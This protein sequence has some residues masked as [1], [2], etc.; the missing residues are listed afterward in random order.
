M[1]EETKKDETTAQP[2]AEE[3]GRVIEERFK[4]IEGK[5]NGIVASHI[6]RGTTQ[7]VL[8]S[9]VAQRLEGLLPDVERRLLDSYTAS[10]TKAPEAASAE[11]KKIAEYEA[12]LKEMNERM[13][14]DSR[15]RAN[16][17]QKRL[18]LEEKSRLA[19]ELRLAGVPDSR[20]RAAVALVYT[21][22][23]RVGRNANGDV[24]YFVPKDGYTDEVSLSDGVKEW[25]K[26]DEGKVFLPPRD[27]SGSGSK[28]GT[29]VNSSGNSKL[30][31]ADKMNLL[32]T[33]LKSH[34]QTP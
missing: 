6:K 25:M 14:A 23:K 7:D 13:E 11:A 15:E 12:K 3:I 33:L 19:D 8:K 21:E 26:S 28:G 24:V 34:G 29:M 5:L 30:S 16:E 9:F 4:S 31:D 22:D 20:V 32:G 17:K 27:A 10:T 1:S 18:S 2:L